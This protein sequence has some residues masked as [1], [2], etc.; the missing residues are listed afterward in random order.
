MS[1]GNRGV[2]TRGAALAV[3]VLRAGGGFE[4]VHKDGR[5]EGLRWPGGTPDD[6]PTLAYVAALAESRG[7][8]CDF[9]DL[10]RRQPGAWPAIAATL[11]IEAGKGPDEAL[12]PQA[13]AILNEPRFW[14]IIQGLA[15][16]L[17]A[18]GSL[19]E[20]QVT[21]AVER[22]PFMPGDSLPDPG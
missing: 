22:P 17:L 6:L 4:A 8:I 18:R 12:R 19:T 21:A 7:H 3:V 16:A 2:A 15:G 20:E 9:K 5:L 14:A 13:V 11:G 1:S 10:R